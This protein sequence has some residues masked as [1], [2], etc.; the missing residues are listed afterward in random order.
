MVKPRRL[1]VSGTNFIVSNLPVKWENKIAIQ[2]TEKQFFEYVPIYA[3]TALVKLRLAAGLR[4]DLP[5]KLTAI[6]NSSQVT[7]NHFLSNCKLS[8]SSTRI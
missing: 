7:Q 8:L 5:R 3:Y 6:P 2:Y 1:R 4:P